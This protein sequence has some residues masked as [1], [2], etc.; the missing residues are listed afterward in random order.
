MN[1]QCIL[2]SAQSSSLDINLSA[3]SNAYKKDMRPVEAE[4]C[5]ETRKLLKLQKDFSDKYSFPFKGLS[6]A[7]TVTK[8]LAASSN[9]NLFN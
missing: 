2:F 9:N 6:V 4:L 7:R 8:L 3:A 1:S 5:D